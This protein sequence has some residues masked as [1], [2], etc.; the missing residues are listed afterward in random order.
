MVQ[1]HGT[2]Q[3]TEVKIVDKSKR[4]YDISIDSTR[5]LETV[6]QKDPKRF[7]HICPRI[8]SVFYSAF[9][10]FFKFHGS[11]P[12]GSLSV[13]LLVYSMVLSFEL[14]LSL[15]FLMHIMNPFSLVWSLGFSYLFILPAITV[16]A[17]LLGVVA[18]FAG[19]PRMMMA[20]SSMNSTMALINYP[21]TLFTMFF[22]KDQA[23]YIGI[24]TML[25]FN[26]MFLSFFGGKV[27]Q[28]FKN[29]AYAY[30]YA[31]MQKHLEMALKADTSGRFKDKTPA[32]KAA[33]LVKGGTPSLDQDNHDSDDDDIPRA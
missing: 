15:I 31:K 24:L 18:T 28:H 27:R 13:L 20:Y 7:K 21:L 33:L 26:K 22:F 25:F 17:P 5:A 3:T 1:I 12:T 16:L 32:E 10:L 2:N 11:P 19:S 6:L 23:I 29:P 9:V 14:I 30:T 4:A 8:R